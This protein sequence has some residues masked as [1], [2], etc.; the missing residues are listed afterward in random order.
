MA[1][2]ISIQLY[3]PEFEKIP[4]FDKFPADWWDLKR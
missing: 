3:T 1:T 2:T 4:E